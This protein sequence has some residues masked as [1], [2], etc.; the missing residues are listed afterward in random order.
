MAVLSKRNL[1]IAIISAAKEQK[2]Y[3]LESVYFGNATYILGEQ[4]EEI[5]KLTKAEVLNENL[6]KSR[7]I[8]QADWHK[9]I[10]KL[11]SENL[12]A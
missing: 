8:H 6:Y 1:L 9:Q 10:H 4:W 5:S 11:L 12:S 7:I 2:L 3:L